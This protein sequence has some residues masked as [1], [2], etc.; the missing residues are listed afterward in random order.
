MIKPYY[1]ISE[2]GLTIR[3]EK[4]CYVQKLGILFYIHYDGDFN[5]KS[6]LDDKYYNDF[7]QYYKNYL[8]NR[9]TSVAGNPV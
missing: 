7:I 8:D 4:I 3:L 1:E 9:N 5:K 2:E 6:Q